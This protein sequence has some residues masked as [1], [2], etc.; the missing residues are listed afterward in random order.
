MVLMTI[1]CAEEAPILADAAR[2]LAVDEAD[3]DR[4]FGVVA[5]DPDRHLFAVRVAADAVKAAKDD[6][7]GYRGPYSD[8]KIAPF[9]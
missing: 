7:G 3:L 6:K 8:P 4:S 9:R 2:L 1:E 5:I